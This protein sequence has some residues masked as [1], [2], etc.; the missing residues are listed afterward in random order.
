MQQ[1]GWTQS[2]ILIEVSQTRRNIVWHPLYVESKK[3]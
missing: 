3:K 2:I 1:H